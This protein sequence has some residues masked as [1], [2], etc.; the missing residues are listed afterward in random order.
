MKKGVK[1]RK[2]KAHRSVVG[3]KAGLRV[4]LR[5]SSQ[6]RNLPLVMRGGGGGA[7]NTMPGS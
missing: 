6:R 1:Q 7:P 2:E 4:N 3:P 5:T